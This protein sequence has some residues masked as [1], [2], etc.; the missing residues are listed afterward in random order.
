[1]KLEEISF[2]K[3]EESIK[4]G[5]KFDLVSLLEERELGMARN[6]VKK[7]SLVGEMGFIKGGG[8]VN[9]FP[10]HMASAT[11]AIRDRLKLSDF[12]IEVRDARVTILPILLLSS[13]NPPQFNL[14]C[15][16]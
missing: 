3:V 12:V 7:A 9:W 8:K 11:R 2:K 16:C 6:A 15:I 5:S 10:G 14:S 13:T 1:M 4:K